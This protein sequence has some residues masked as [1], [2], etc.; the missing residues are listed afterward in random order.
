MVSGAV[1]LR[2]GHAAALHRSHGLQLR[3]AR[4]Q[5]GA[6]LAGGHLLAGGAAQRAATGGRQHAGGGGGCLRAIEAVA[7]GAL[8]T[9][10]SAWSVAG[11]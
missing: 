4:L 9:E 3:D 8:P 10:T 6:P 2:G 7:T 11:R 5:A 1:A